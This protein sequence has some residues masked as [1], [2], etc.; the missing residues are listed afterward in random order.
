[1]PQ[2]EEVHVAGLSAVDPLHAALHST[3]FVSLG[4]VKP[5]ETILTDTPRAFAASR[6]SGLVLIKEAP[7]ISNRSRI[8][9]P[10]VSESDPPVVDCATYH[11]LVETLATKLL[12]PGFK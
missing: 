2:F 6:R 11:I 10:V 12:A 1:M 7:S 4:T 5:Q 3:L 8:P 9:N